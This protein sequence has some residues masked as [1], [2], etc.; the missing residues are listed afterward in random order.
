MQVAC[1]Y[2]SRL[3]TYL[4]FQHCVYKVVSSEGRFYSQQGKQI[5]TYLPGKAQLKSVAA[6]S[7]QDFTVEHPNTNIIAVDHM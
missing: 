7:G 2:P 1:S 5:Y 6:M 3:A 4:H